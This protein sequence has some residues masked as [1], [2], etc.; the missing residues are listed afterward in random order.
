MNKKSPRRHWRHR[1]F[2]VRGTQAK[3]NR[4]VQS[5]V[6]PFKILLL[7]H[8][9]FSVQSCWTTWNS[10][11]TPYSSMQFVSCVKNVLSSSPFNFNISNHY[12]SFKHWSNLKFE[13]S[14]C[15]P[16]ALWRQ[17]SIIPLFTNFIIIV[18]SF[19]FHPELWAITLL[20]LCL[21]D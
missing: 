11:H 9:H 8:I 21:S 1:S 16:I 5:T 2:M 15:K 14:H 19:Y 10:Q 20:Y 18:H 4:K 3:W 12:S 7:H 17:N 6:G 13:S